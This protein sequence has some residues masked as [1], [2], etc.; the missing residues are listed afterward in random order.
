MYVYNDKQDAD[1]QTLSTLKFSRSFDA[2]VSWETIDICQVQ[3]C[4]TVPTLQYY[5][6]V[7]MVAYT[8][9]TDLLLAVSHDMGSTWQT[10]AQDPAL[11]LGRSFENSPVVV[12]SDGTLHLFALDLPYPEYD[13]D[14]YTALADP[15]QFVAHKYF[16]HQDLAENGGI[17]PW[18]GDHVIEGILRA[19]SDIYIQQNANGDNGGWP[20]FVSPVIISGEVVSLSGAYPREQ[21]FPGGLIEHAP[22][23]LPNK[24]MLRGSGSTVGP[25]YY[26]ESN[27]VHVRVEGVGYGAYLRQTIP[28]NVSSGVY[29][30]F[31]PDDP[32]NYLFTNNYVVN[33]SVYTFLGSGSTVNRVRWVN[34]KLYISGVFSSGQLWAASDTIFITGDILLS[35]TIPGC[36]P[37]TD[38]IDSL[39]LYSEKSIVFK[40]GG[41]PIGDSVRYHLCRPDTQPFFVYADLIAMGGVYDPMQGRP[42]VFTFE[43]QHPHPSVPDY[44]IG[45]D[46]F[47]GIDL[48]RR[49]Y[50]QTSAE[51][52]PGHIDHPWYNP[53]WP[54]RTP[55]LERGVMHLWGSV[56]Q[57]R[58][59]KLRRE[60]L[61]QD[62]PGQTAWDPGNG[63]YGG[64]SAVDY[65][66]PV[67]NIHLKTMNYPGASGSGIGYKPVYYVNN[68]ATYKKYGTVGESIW[69]VGMRYES[70]DESSLIESC[71][72]YTGS[73][74]RTKL[75]AQFLGAKA[76][77]MNEE[78]LYYTTV[79]R[80]LSLATTGGGNITS[81]SFDQ[82]GHIL[83]AQTKQVTNGYQLRLRLI[84]PLLPTQFIQNTIVV[85]SRMNDLI[86]MPDGRRMLIT[87]SDG[88]LQLYELNDQLQQTLVDTCAMPAGYVAA[89]GKVWLKASNNG[90]LDVYVRFDAGPNNPS[91]LYHCRYGAAS[92]AND[93]QIPMATNIT[94]SAYPNPG[95]S[96]MT[97]CVENAN[98]STTILE[99]YNLKGQKVK[100]LGNPI[101]LGKDRFEY[102]WNGLDEQGRRVSGGVYF[103]R[104]RNRNQVVTK[105]ICWL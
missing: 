36:P 62:D 2:G 3:D 92:P 98:R 60:T 87:Y 16:F 4:I 77:A 71:T 32:D 20:R 1:P 35:T 81:L 15:E 76:F 95:F 10:S 89:N 21:V 6:D 67:L 51:P 29:L 41:T 34:G 44:S 59:G 48:H 50:P 94:L 17:E 7:I 18:T 88:T 54:E 58:K 96:K 53:L 13:Q 74:A 25:T 37:P 26:D 104:V 57:A 56:S 22:Q 23:F 5:P 72:K 11:N 52:W 46:N 30:D 86:V 97:V 93:D 80:D 27:S 78:L 70:L 55:Y 99:V 82:S 61:E 69:S 14:Q 33:D 42:G 45:N 8:H 103:L 43:Y 65:F 12:R 101:P 31:P 38:Q 63:Q 91:L 39:V 28:R 83:V 9:G 40:Y 84:N 24:L 85:S 47:S 68:Y 66:D 90:C 79:T 19:N 105:K 49:R 100:T 73:K 102:E 75:M 64:S